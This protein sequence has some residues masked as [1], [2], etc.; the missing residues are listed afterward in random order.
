MRQ[1]MALK[2]AM[3]QKTGLVCSVG[4]APVRFL[5]KIASDRD[6]PD[7]LVVVDDLEEFLHTVS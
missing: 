3:K 7:G 1:G 2:R 6:K 4:L 5:A